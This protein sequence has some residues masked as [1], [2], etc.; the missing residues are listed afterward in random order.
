MLLQVQ[1]G[2]RMSI[3]EGMRL[4]QAEGA[5]LAVAGSCMVISVV[6]MLHS[7]H[8]AITSAALARGGTQSKT[9]AVQVACS[10][11]GLAWM[12]VMQQQA[13]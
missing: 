2:R 13:V 4:M 11:A 10:A 12:F 9:A 3:R 6:C 1:E 8:L 7:Q 5:A